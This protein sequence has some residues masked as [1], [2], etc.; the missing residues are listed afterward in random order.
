MKEKEKR[1]PKGIAAN[2]NYQITK[3]HLTNEKI[4][5]S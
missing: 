5:V 2:I 4:E 1:R 3:F